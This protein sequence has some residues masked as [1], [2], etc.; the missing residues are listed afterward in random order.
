MCGRGAALR[1]ALC[2]RHVPGAAGAPRLSGASAAVRAARR[3]GSAPSEP[4]AAL[5][6]KRRLRNY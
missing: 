1:C 4:R 2:G 3:G 6:V 5:F